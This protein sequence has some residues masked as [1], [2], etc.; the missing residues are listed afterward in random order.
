MR[1]EDHRV[2]TKGDKANNITP[3]PLTVDIYTQISLPIKENLRD[4]AFASITPFP[5]STQPRVMVIGLKD[6]YDKFVTMTIRGK[7]RQI[8]ANYVDADDVMQNYDKINAEIS[9]TVI[10]AVI[11]SK[12]PFQ[13]VIVQLSNVKEDDDILKSQNDQMAAKNKVNEILAIGEAIKNNPQYLQMKKYEVLE[14]IG[15][16]ANNLSVI[17]S[18]GKEPNL[19]IK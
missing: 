19:L 14:K 2:K 3:A 15:G 11:L 8:F 10:D 13:V 18:E 9:T 12:A 5:D 4:N 1:G 16:K 17:F 6:I 7:V